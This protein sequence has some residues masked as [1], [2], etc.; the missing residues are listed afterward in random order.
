M[1]DAVDAVLIL[2]SRAGA[3]ALCAHMKTRFQVPLLPVLALV[4]RPGRRPPDATAPDAWLAAASPPSLVADRVEEL[5]RI[6][7]AERE[8]VRL[9]ASLVGLAA[10]NG[11][12]YDRARRD[13]EATTLLLRELQHRVRNNLASIQALLIL[14]R[15]RRPARALSEAIDVAIARLRSMAALQD[16]LHVD[17]GNVRLGPLCVAICR[18]VVEV[19]GAAAATRIEV[20]G[21]ATTPTARASGIAIVLTELVTNAILHAGAGRIAIAIGTSAGELTLTIEDDGRGFGGDTR[22]G[23]G[24]AIAHAVARNELHGALRRQQT[25]RGSRF[26]LTV[27]DEATSL[28]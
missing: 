22:A 21:D 7:R 27:P 26:R 20:V 11:R 28:E 17:T 3:L 8:L 1:D 19:F 4:P 13:A 10:E 18:S 9:N 24:L 6:R 12:L 5:V 15:H 2:A 16:A 23:S 14:E 25:A